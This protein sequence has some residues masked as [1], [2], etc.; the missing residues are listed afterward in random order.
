MYQAM[1]NPLRW[2]LMMPALLNR[3]RLSIGLILARTIFMCVVRTDL[4]LGLMSPAGL[5]TSIYLSL[6]WTSR[7]ILLWIVSRRTCYSV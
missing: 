5:M 4:A 3:Q 1:R 6:A 7:Q 2:F